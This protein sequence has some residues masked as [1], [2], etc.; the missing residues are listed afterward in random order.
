[1]LLGECLCFVGRGT[2]KGRRRGGDDL[3]CY[4][5]NEQEQT[6]TTAPDVPAIF[7]DDFEVV[8]DKKTAWKVRF[9]RATVPHLQT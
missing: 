2:R 9:K 3:W 6:L 7:G 5:S 4:R 8:M 1:M